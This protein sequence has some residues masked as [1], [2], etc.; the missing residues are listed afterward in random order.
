MRPIELDWLRRDFE[1]GI[2]PALSG[3]EEEVPPLSPAAYRPVPAPPAH[4]ERPGAAAACLS[5]P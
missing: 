1:S 5:G 3:A 2:L 4:P